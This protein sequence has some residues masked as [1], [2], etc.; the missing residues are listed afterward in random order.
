MSSHDI[1]S[2]IGPTLRC[3]SY[4]RFSDTSQ[5]AES[6]EDQQR[7][8]A[9]TAKRHGLTIS[10]ELGF[11]DRAMSGGDAATAKRTGYQ[12]L[13]K[14]WDAGAFDV[15]IVDEVSRLARSLLELAKLQERVKLTGVRV[16]TCDGLDSA[17]QMWSLT[18]AIAAALAS[19]ELVELRFRV[20]RGMVGALLR[21]RQIGYPP[22]GYKMLQLK[23]G[24]GDPDG[25]IWFK[26][27]ATA[28]IVKEMFSMRAVL[29][30]SLVQIAAE[31]NRRGIRTSTIRGTGG[32]FW[33]PATVR[34][35]L[36]NTIYRGVF[37]LNGSPFT[38]AKAKRE[39]R[40]IV[41]EVFDRPQLRLVDDELWDA[42]NPKGKSW[43]RR[44]TSSPLSG[45]VTCKQCSNP[46]TVTHHGKEGS[47]YC[48]SCATESRVGARDGYLGNVTVPIVKAALKVVF[49]H[50]L[51]SDEMLDRVRAGLRQRL[52]SGVEEEIEAVTVKVASTKRSAD[53][54]R[55]MLGYVPPDEYDNIK[56]EYLKSAQEA[57]GLRERLAQL[58]AL[59]D[60]QDA[61]AI[62]AQLTV[63]PRR[64]MGGLFETAMPAGQLRAL[65]GRVFPRVTFLG[66]RCR[67]GGLFEIDVSP[68]VVLADATGTRV[69]DREATR[70]FVQVER[71]P[72]LP[73][74]WEAR[75][76]ESLP[77]V[78][79]RAC[80]KRLS[81]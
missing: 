17:Q 44:G 38:I 68:G 50:V 14:A 47:L 1:D 59:A 40:K 80:T 36:R 8:I 26:D 25:T 11:A 46:L 33:R 31:L 7:R 27:E 16:I 12:A 78:R 10:P 24:N 15:L 71:G 2:V 63:D 73:T 20:I 34:A 42:A 45:L 41:Q 49:E 22:F 43:V 74:T 13:L 77:P 56:A 54:Y 51:V 32:K 48:A 72:R 52:M 9:E 19:H 81:K 64:L 65:L 6:I 58:K 61:A 76:V 37:V 79:G 57:S 18:F 5:K 30:M 70:V 53:R 75:I 69:I 66:K 29:G 28:P 67:W 62:E 4:A 60:S 21:D 3:A 23:K 55:S 35:I 39:G